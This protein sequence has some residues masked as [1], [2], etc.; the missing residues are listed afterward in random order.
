MLWCMKRQSGLTAST[1]QWRRQRAVELHQQ[2]WTQ[3]AIAQALGVTAG[4]VCQWLKARR[5]QGEQALLSQRSRAGKRPK[6]TPEQ[7]KELLALL[8]AGAE[9]SGQIG[10]RWDGKRVAALIKRHFGVS[11]LPTSIPPLLRQLGWSPQKPRI[12]AQQRNEAAIEQFQQEWPDIKKGQ[13]PKAVP[14]SS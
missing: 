4:A 7:Q 10:E 12:L 11:Y 3:A 2:G 13:K 5:E 9:E 8:D 14:S 6:L 1:E